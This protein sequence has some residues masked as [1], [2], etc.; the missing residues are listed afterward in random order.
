[1]NKIKQW[2]NKNWNDIQIYLMWSM[3]MFVPIIWI[4]VIG[5]LFK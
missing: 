2:I 4:I 5:E 3:L 1:M